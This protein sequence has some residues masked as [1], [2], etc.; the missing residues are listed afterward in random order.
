MQ[1]RCERA[2]ALRNQYKGGIS[3]RIQQGRITGM[4]DES[5]QPQTMTPEQQKVFFAIADVF[6]NTANDLGDDHPPARISA[7]MMFATARWNA[8]VAQ[9]QG[10]PPGEIDEDAISYF[11]KEYEVMLRENMA[12]ILSSR[13]VKGI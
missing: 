7:A 12:Q 8:F 13:Q 9:A 2:Y 3:A 5:G 6:V 1:I 10:L 11:L 4:S